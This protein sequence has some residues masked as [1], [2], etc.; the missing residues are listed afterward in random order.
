LF[1]PYWQVCY[2]VIV[3]GFE[4]SGADVTFFDP[5][6]V[7]EDQVAIVEDLIHQEPDG[8]AL[9]CIDSNGNVP[10]VEK[11]ERAGIPIFTA[12]IR[13]NTEELTFHCGYDQMMCGEKEAEY[14]NT[15][16]ERM[17][18]SLVVYQIACPLT[19][20]KCAEE[21]MGFEARAEELPMLEVYLAPD[22]GDMWG[23]EAHM[24]L[25][26]DALAAHPDINCI[27]HQGALYEGIREALSV[28]GH[29][30][31]V[32]HPDHFAWY[33]RAASSS[34][35][36]AMRDGYLTGMFANDAWAVSDA[37]CKAVLNQVCLGNAIPNR[38]DL[39]FEAITR[40]TL[41]A[42][43][44]GMPKRWGDMLEIEPD[45]TQWPVLDMSAVGM[46]TPQPNH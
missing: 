11:A 14:L 42:P 43:A 33:G 12:D 26:M 23:E 34:G 40:E 20:E 4:R 7:L 22:I 46:P 27:V 21:R 30:Y 36:N 5:Q 16:A 2:N 28:T 15:E 13:A 8:I 18:H 44:W 9:Y 35:C 25:I 38:L 32:W 17:G 39:P 1:D 19:F 29:L 41:D 31:P 37:V 10:V 6:F 3:S 45:I 24:N